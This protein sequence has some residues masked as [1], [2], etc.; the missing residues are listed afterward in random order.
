MHF[1]NYLKFLPLDEIII[2]FI[3]YQ[4]NE[5]STTLLLALL[6]WMVVIATICIELYIHRYRLFLRHSSGRFQH[7]L[8]PLPYPEEGE[9]SA[10]CDLCHGKLGTS[11]I[12]VCACGKKFHPECIAETECPGCG[13][14]LRHMQVRS[15]SVFMCPQCLV[16]AP[17]GQCPECGATYPR[18][19]GTFKC[20]ECGS[21]VLPSELACRR[22]GCRYVARRTNGY[23]PR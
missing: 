16:P 5:M 10:F 6:I 13:N 12:A 17:G 8:H 22:C 14:D 3:T 23:K 19:D 21:N 2:N 1:R 11:E 15:P 9:D 20:S 7:F 4:R 18:R